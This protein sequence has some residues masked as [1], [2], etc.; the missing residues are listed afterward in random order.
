MF[1]RNGKTLYQSYF[2][3]CGLTP[4][5]AI[6]TVS[7]ITTVGLSFCFGLGFGFRNGFGRSLATVSTVSVST[8][9][10]SGGAGHDNSE[11]ELKKGMV[12]TKLV[13]LMITKILLNLK[14]CNHDL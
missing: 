6:S 3:V 13:I 14:N 2:G 4:V 12:V 8:V 1:S 5:S 7:T 10:F 9:G 11:Y